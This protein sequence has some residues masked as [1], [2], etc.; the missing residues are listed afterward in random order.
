MVSDGQQSISAMVIVDAA[1]VEV[2]MEAGQAVSTLATVITLR[3]ADIP[4]QVR[5]GH[6][7]TVGGKTYRVD[8]AQLDGGGMVRCIVSVAA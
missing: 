3:E 6:R 8:D 1:W 7:V 5:A 4:W 2:P